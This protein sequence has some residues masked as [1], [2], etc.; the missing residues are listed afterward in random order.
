M[1]RLRELLIVG[2]FGIWLMIMGVALEVSVWVIGG[3][4]VG[5]ELMTMG[6]FWRLG[7]EKDGSDY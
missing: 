3:M 5:A 1:G 4:V 2:V 7:K 6:V